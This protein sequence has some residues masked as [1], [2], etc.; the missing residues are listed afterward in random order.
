MQLYKPKPLVNLSVFFVAVHRQR[1]PYTM[2]QWLDLFQQMPGN[3]FLLADTP[4]ASEAKAVD[5]G[6][7]DLHY[8][9][10]QTPTPSA[11]T[12]TRG[13][14]DDIMIMSRDLTATPFTTALLQT[15]SLQP[16]QRKR[17]SKYDNI[18]ARVQAM[19]EEFHEYRK[20][21]ALQS[22]RNSSTTANSASFELESAC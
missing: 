14:Q 3:R 2:D 18:E 20:R 13:T 12:P 22:Q 17:A 15:H 21:Q 4:I 8:E 5:V 9:F 11:S 16:Y 1:S 6:S 19:K 7:V 10:D